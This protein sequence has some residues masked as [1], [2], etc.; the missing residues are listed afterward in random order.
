MDIV[1]MDSE[2]DTSSLFQILKFN[3]GSW[4]SKILN[5]LPSAWFE[6]LFYIYIFSI[7]QSL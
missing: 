1:D 5:L 4:D 3:L 7:S 2:I 6:F